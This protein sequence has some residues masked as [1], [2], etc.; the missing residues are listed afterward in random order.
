MK[1]SGTEAGSHKKQRAIVESDKE[2]G[3][4]GRD[5]LP[6]HAVN[7]IT[8]EH[9]PA[10]KGYKAQVKL[11]PGSK[12]TCKAKNTSNSSKQGHRKAGTDGR[13]GQP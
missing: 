4:P 1:L 12:P 6:K 8:T 9:L 5:I 7:N 2:Y 10:M 13:S 3:L 11:I